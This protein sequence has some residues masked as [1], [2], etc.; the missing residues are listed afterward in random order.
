[1]KKK[2]FLASLMVGAAALTLSSCGSSTIDSAT[3]Y[4]DLNLNAT[5]AKAKDYTLTTRDYYNQLR[6]NASSLVN[7]KI[8]K[9]LY[10]KEY[11]E[12]REKCRGKN[13]R[14]INF[15]RI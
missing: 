10:Q 3:P 11:N 4:G 15:R 9:A 1:M 6:Y 5:V 8:E 12:L 14:Y 13:L 2:L 7:G